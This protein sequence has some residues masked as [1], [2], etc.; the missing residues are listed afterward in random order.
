MLYYKHDLDQGIVQ[1]RAAI[2][3]NP[4]FALAHVN[5]AK[6]LATKGQYAEAESEFRSAIVLAPE[7]AAAHLGLGLLLATSAG[8]VSLEARAEMN[9]G[10]RLD[11]TLKAAIPAEYIS[12]LN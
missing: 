12:Q 1:F 9:E 2:A 11:P 8:K 5:L 6:S 7:M 4:G 3:A 10:L